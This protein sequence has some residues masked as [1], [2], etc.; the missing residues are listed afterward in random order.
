VNIT[1]KI[2]F[3]KPSISNYAPFPVLNL[4]LKA[5]ILLGL[6]ILLLVLQSVID[7]LLKSFWNL[8]N[9]FSLRNFGWPL[10]TFIRVAILEFVTALATTQCLQPFD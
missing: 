10:S 8:I 2:P 7:I 9:N 4:Q 6:K 3:I 1:L 5:K